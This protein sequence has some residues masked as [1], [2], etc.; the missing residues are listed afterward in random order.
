MRSW[1]SALILGC[2]VLAGCTGLPR[3]A[4]SVEGIDQALAAAQR[5]MVPGPGVVRLGA[6]GSLR[7]GHD[8]LFIPAGE[9]GRLLTALGEGPRPALLGLVVI[10]APA[11]ADYAAIYARAPRAGYPDFD[12]V[13]WRSAPALAGLVPR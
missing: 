11:G 8:R 1:G 2:A 9:G 3:F 13:G 7:L 10:S 4:S 6:N 5:A 12:V